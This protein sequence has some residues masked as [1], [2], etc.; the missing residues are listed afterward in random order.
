M[1]KIVYSHTLSLGLFYGPFPE[2]HS[3]Q[4]III[5]E[6]QWLSVSKSPDRSRVVATK[7]ETRMYWLYT[8]AHR[9][10]NR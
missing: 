3:D 8:K 6:K 4:D 9:L 10:M 5:N 1:K 7:E 2:I